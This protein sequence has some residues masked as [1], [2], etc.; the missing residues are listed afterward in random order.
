M[1]TSSLLSQNTVLDGKKLKSIISN[2]LVNQN[3]EA[4]QEEG[5]S[6]TSW[7][8]SLWRIPFRS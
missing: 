3:T 8:N 2:P 5:L 7:L 4:P 6:D 1:F